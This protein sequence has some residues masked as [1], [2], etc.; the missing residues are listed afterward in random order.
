MP[1]A[2]VL[3]QQRFPVAPSPQTDTNGHNDHQVVLP[4][5]STLFR[6]GCPVLPSPCGRLPAGLALPYRPAA[7]ASHRETEDAP[8]PTLGLPAMH[9]C[10]TAAVR[11]RPNGLS[12]A[13]PVTTTPL[14]CKCQTSAMSPQ[15][16][17]NR[18]KRTQTTQC[19]TVSGT[20]GHK[21]IQ[22]D[23]L[24]RRKRL[25]VLPIFLKQTAWG[26]P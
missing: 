11:S 24:A 22:F 25:N 15:T 8:M 26:L 2:T 7:D 16:D 18:H 19:D 5:V 23:Y 6:V 21:A 4:C 1:S 3:V 17:T 9:H 20:I 14:L 13:S 10:I 12:V